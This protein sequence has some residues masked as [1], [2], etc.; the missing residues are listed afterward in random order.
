MQ[1]IYLWAAGVSKS[2]NKKENYKLKWQTGL[3][4]FYV[5]ICQQMLMLLFKYY[6][7]NKKFF[8]CILNVIVTFM[9]VFVIVWFH[10]KTPSTLCVTFVIQLPPTLFSELKTYFVLC[11]F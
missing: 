6:V 3:L 10:K 7:M 8:K 11:A 5:R 1:P 9:E 2:E 4:L